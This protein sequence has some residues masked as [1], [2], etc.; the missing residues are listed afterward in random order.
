MQTVSLPLGYRGW[1]PP[2]G[3]N[4]LIGDSK[5]PVFPFHQRA[6]LWRK[7]EVTI[8]YA[9]THTTGF[10][11]DSSPYSAPSYLEEGPRFELGDVLPSQLSKLMLYH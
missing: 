2:K 10:K 7:V 6:K 1:K 5:S 3:S 4:L 9:F 11:P 8:P